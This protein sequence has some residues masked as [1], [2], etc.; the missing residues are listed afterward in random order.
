MKSHINYYKKRIE[1]ALDPD[2][3]TV[4]S[5]VRLH[6]FTI[7]NEATNELIYPESKEWKLLGK[8]EA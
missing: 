5:I 2:T 4:S 8:N 3:D 6:H 7:R 1:L